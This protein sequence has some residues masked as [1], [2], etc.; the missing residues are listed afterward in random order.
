M[1]KYLKTNIHMNGITELYTS[2]EHIV[3]NQLYINKDF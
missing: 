3:V 1:E 2:N